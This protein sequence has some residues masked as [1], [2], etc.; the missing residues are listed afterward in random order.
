MTRAERYRAARD[1]LIEVDQEIMGGTAIIRGPRMT[2]YSVLGRIEH[3]I[4]LTT[5]WLRTPICRM[6]QSKLQSSMHEI[7]LSIG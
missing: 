3:V 7:K 4:A 1:A 2:V 6:K 5:S